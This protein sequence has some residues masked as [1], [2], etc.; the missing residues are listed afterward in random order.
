MRYNHPASGGA[1]SGPVH[2]DGGRL[3]QVDLL[4]G[5]AALS[6]VYFHL[7]RSA[8]LTDETIFNSGYFGAYG[9]QVFFAISG[10]VIPFGMYR[11][12]YK[13]SSFARYILK[14]IIRIDPPYLISIAI[15]PIVGVAGMGST[16]EWP[17]VQRLLLHIGYLNVLTSNDWLSPFYWTLA[18]E[19]Q[20]YIFVGLFFR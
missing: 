6:V 18:I 8:G 20:Y 17:S 3:L 11:S 7:S 13:P 2:Y 9:V 15:G 5:L 1:A 4:R 10:F 12:G 14:R 19:F 16:F